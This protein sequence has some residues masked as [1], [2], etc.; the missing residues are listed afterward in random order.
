LSNTVDVVEFSAVAATV[1]SGGLIA[2]V[3]LE[4]LFVP[5]SVA[6]QD[7]RNAIA[8][9]TAPTVMVAVRERVRARRD[10]GLFMVTS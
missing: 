4:A 8:I 10:R 3:S 9:A 1:D 7:P 2:V 5:A 6:A